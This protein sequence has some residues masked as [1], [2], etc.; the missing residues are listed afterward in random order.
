LQEVGHLVGPEVLGVPV[1]FILGIM[2]EAVGASFSVGREPILAIIG[3]RY[4]MDSADGGGVLAEF[5]SG[6]LFGSLFIAIVSWFM[7]CLGIFHP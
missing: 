7:A 1:G 5:L 4:G 3:E 6:T 2:S